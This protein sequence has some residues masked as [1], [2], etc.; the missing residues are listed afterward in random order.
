MER[1]KVPIRLDEHVLTELTSQHYLPT[2]YEDVFRDIVTRSMTGKPE[3]ALQA[4]KILSTSNTVRNLLINK[5]FSKYSVKIERSFD[6]STIELFPLNQN[7]VLDTVHQE[8]VSLPGIQEQVTK[9]ANTEMLRFGVLTIF[10]ALILACGVYVAGNSMPELNNTENDLTQLKLSV[11]AGVG[12]FISF[13][14]NG[15]LLVHR[16]ST[17][18]LS[19]KL[20]KQL[21]YYFTNTKEKYLNPL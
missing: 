4:L 5:L 14:G 6:E 18:T 15:L 21:K 13:I 10:T 11:S 17:V 20:Y 1:I 8:L 3:T 7:D 19:A 16:R 12:M 2:D 9:E